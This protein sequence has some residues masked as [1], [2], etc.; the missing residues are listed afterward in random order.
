MMRT[1]AIIG[2]I[3]VALSIWDAISASRI[4]RPPTDCPDCRPAI[5]SA[6]L[7]R[8]EVFYAHGP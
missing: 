1:L 7:A 2:A 3:M 8:A 5:R 4:P 6:L